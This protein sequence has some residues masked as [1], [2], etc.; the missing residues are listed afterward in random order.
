M[1][2]IPEAV[3]AYGGQDCAG[4]LIIDN[5][6][7]QCVFAAAD[8]CSFG[9]KKGSAE[10]AKIAVKNSLIAAHEQ[11]KNRGEGGVTTAVSGAVSLEKDEQGKEQ[12][13]LHYAS[14]GDSQLIL[15]ATNPD[16]TPH[17]QKFVQPADVIEQYL[18]IEGFNYDSVQSLQ[19]IKEARQRIVDKNGKT[20]NRV[21]SAATA[22]INSF[23]GIS[24]GNDG[25]GQSFRVN[26]SAD[27]FG[28]G[29]QNVKLIVCSDN[30]G[31]K[32]DE[33]TV[34]AAYG[35]GR[36]SNRELAAKLNMAMAQK[37]ADD[38]CL[39]V[40]SVGRQK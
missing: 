15:L 39:A 16:G 37:D 40:I 23:L 8:G 28:K 34:K 6:R 35:F 18:R 17:L 38:G 3:L 1:I 26:L 36:T 30:V 32:I 12:I 25:S 14:V 2:N 21:L 20:D 31:E 29:L 33:E 27:V 5:G 13:Y 22:G 4:V 24:E 9:D 11:I 7:I 19:Q 10:A